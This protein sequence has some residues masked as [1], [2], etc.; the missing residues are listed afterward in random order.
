[1]KYSIAIY[2]LLTLAIMSCRTYEQLPAPRVVQ[3]GTNPINTVTGV[4]T[5]TGTTTSPGTNTTTDGTNTTTTGNNTVPGVTT[6]PGIEEPVEATSL[7][8]YVYTNLPA[9]VGGEVNSSEGH[10]TLFS[11]RTNSIVPLSDSATTKWDIGFKSTTLIF[12]SGTSGPGNAGVIIQNG[13]Y[14]NAA[15]APTTGY[16]QDNINGLPPYALNTGSGNGWYNYNSDVHVIS[17]VP[18][19]YLIVRTANEK[20]AKVEIL[21]YYKDAPP[22]PTSDTEGRYYKFRYSFQG[23]GSTT[24]K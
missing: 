1:M 3:T 8:S 23:D 7:V 14:E 9:A 5:T 19:R 10:Y 15:T 24:L 12:N 16:K 20:Y 11:L 18:G 21:S 2:L 22:N 6:T 17:P 4:N 13:I